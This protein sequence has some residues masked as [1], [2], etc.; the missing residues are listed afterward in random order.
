[1]K[2]TYKIVIVAA[3][4]LIIIS[5]IYYF[6]SS[7]SYIESKLKNTL[8]ETAATIFETDE[9]LNGNVAPDTYVTTLNDLESKLG[10]DTSLFE[11]YNCDKEN[12]KVEFIVMKQKKS[13]QTNYKYN[14]ILD[15]DF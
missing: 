5:I 11:K 6:T 3:I 12:T 7:P 1:M 14:I 9:W 10:K 13:K 15:C 2:R 4:F 8:R